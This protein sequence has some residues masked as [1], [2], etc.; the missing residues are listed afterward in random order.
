MRIQKTSKTADVTVAYDEYI[1]EE[2]R[3]IGQ[4]RWDSHLKMWRFP[5]H[6]YQALM[7]LKHEVLKSN[8]PKDEKL[9]VFKEHMLRKGYSIQT[10][11][12]YLNHLN[13]YLI[14]SNN[15]VDLD[16]IN[17]YICIM[18][19]R[20]EQSFTYVNQ[21]VS[22]LKL[23]CRY[24]KEFSIDDIVSMER[25]KKENKLPKVMSK[26]Q[27]K[28]L[29]DAT[30][31]LKY[32]TAMM[33]SYS[34]GL[35]VSEVSKLKISDIDSDQM[36]IRVNQGKGRKDRLVPLSEH[37]LLQLRNYYKV[38]QPKEWLFENRI[39]DHLTTRSFQKVFERSR[40]KACLKSHVTFHSL[41]HSFA[42]HLLEEG[43]NLRYIQ[44]ILGHASSKTTEVY[45]RVST[46]HYKN[47]HNPLDTLFKG[48]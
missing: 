5:I 1:V 20:Q 7:Y 18:M 40:A 27:L 15:Y 35:R 34:A 10:I 21:L 36:L 19:Y 13:R 38:F 31:N 6:K 47:I 26:D 43:V 17:D 16:L 24:T 46:K 4:G 8:L 2:L 25:P 12:A 44:E 29:F 11:K 48:S 22:S 42:T 9:K 28:R 33:V 37:L 30:D 39:G 14:F 41:R 45:T 32:K 23:Y 3:K